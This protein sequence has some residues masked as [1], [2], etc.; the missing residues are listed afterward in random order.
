MAHTTRQEQPE[1]QMDSGSDPEMEVPVLSPVAPGAPKPAKRTFVRTILLGPTLA[2]AQPTFGDTDDEL[3]VSDCDDRPNPTVK[4]QK[5][6]AKRLD[7]A[8]ESNLAA[9]LDALAC[10]GRSVFV[11][12]MNY[13]TG[14][15]AA[16][17]AHVVECFAYRNGVQAE[18]LD[19]VDETKEWEP[20]RAELAGIA[21]AAFEIAEILTTD[22]TSAVVVVSKKGGNAAKL[23]AGCAA[24]A[25]RRLGSQEQAKSIVGGYAP[26]PVGA[27]KRIYESFP[28][29]TKTT[30][31]HE[32]TAFA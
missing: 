14:N 2:V 7:F 17:I 16:G 5:R 32:I 27:L 6:P 26:Q 31:P 23:M 30:A 24:Q 15:R 4:K 10:N 29:W 18:N 22:D 21:V 9:K 19:V 11:F 28:K 20:G 3:G 1:K 25:V 13:A 8:S 12:P